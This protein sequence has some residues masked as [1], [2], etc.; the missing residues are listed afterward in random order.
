MSLTGG[1]MCSCSLNSL[2]SC[3]SVSMFVLDDEFDEEGWC[4][5]SVCDSL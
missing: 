4:R 3:V 1:L 5:A 2:H